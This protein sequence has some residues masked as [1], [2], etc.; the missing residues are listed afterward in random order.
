M[1]PSVLAQVTNA[2]P[3]NAGVAAEVSTNE[4][5]TDQV[6]EETSDTTTNA[7]FS[8][9]RH[10]F[11]VRARRHGGGSPLIRIGHDVELKK[12]ETAEAVV[13]VG[14][15]V[16]IRGKVREAVVV[17]GGNLDIEGGEIGDAAV[18]VL[19]DVRAGQGSIIHGDLVSVGG[20]TDLAEGAKIEGEIVD[21]G[22]LGLPQM[23]WLKEWLKQ[24]VLKLRPLAPRVGWVWGVWGVF[25]L[26]YLLIAAAFP[27]PV[28][29]CV[30]ELTRRPATTF[31][32]GLLTKL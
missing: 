8:V 7:G 18:V 27:R 23:P 14:G 32:M 12:G 3:T 15:S 10:G 28:R 19:G 22:N 9:G 31:L 5:A 6:A 2:A 1:T 24:C 16:K 13:V 11:R 17:V 26:V 21:T 30:D 20:K 4:A 29:A 25:L